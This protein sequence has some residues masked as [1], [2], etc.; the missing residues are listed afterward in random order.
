MME[1][2]EEIEDLKKYYKRVHICQKCS[3]PFGS[4]TIDEYNPFCPNCNGNACR[5]RKENGV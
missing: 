5:R 4:D 3:K 2:K 1:E